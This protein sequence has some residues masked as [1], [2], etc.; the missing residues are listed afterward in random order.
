METHPLKPF[1]PKSARALMLGTFPPKREK[2]C[3][4]F[5]YPNA[6]NDMWRIFGLAFFGDRDFFWDAPAKRFRKDKIAEFLEYAGIALY[7]TAAV[8][9]PLKGNASAN[10]LENVRMG[11]L[12]AFLGQTP[13]C[14]AV[15]C[16]GAKAAETA[17]E[18]MGCRAPKQGS[19]GKISFEGRNLKFYRMPSSSRAYP[20]KLEKKAEIY[21]A[22][23]GELGF[24][25]RK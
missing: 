13:A 23:F 3:M 24:P 21:S 5:F 9:N 20:M 6:V 4:D 15:V 19:M 10:F 1:L 16:T 18:T 11:D 12:Q 8:G 7:D 2:W 14:E 25:V 17:A 22:M